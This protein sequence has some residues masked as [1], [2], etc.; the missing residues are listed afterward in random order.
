VVCGVCCHAVVNQVWVK[1][2]Q[3]PQQAS[4]AV[5]TADVVYL[6]IG[7]YL[8][9]STGSQPEPCIRLMHDGSDDTVWFKEVPFG[10]RMMIIYLLG[11]L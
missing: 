10:I 2:A 8:F 11:G 3:N 9:S 1:A 5:H 6:Y 7:L 4:L